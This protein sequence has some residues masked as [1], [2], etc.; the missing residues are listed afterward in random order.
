MDGSKIM[1]RWDD[2]NGTPSALSNKTTILRYSQEFRGAFGHIGLV[3]V[4]E[5]IMPMIGGAANTAFAADMLGISHI[6]AA[7]A[8]GAIAGFVH[9]Y[10]GSVQTPSDAATAAI[11][12]IAALGKGDFYDVA[13]V[14]SLELDSVAV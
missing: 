6:D 11:P 1:G 7:H 14:A 5:F 2:L 10:N 12:V 4:N 9:P 13:S 8:Q 3:G